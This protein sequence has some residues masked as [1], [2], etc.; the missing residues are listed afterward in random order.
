VIEPFHHLESSRNTPPGPT[1]TWSMFRWEAARSWKM[2]QPWDSSLRRVRPADCPVL[3][4]LD[5]G[6]RR[7]AGNHEHR[8]DHAGHQACA[9]AQAAPLGSSQVG[10]DDQRSKDGRQD[11]EAARFRRSQAW[12]N[13]SYFLLAPSP[14]F[15]D[16]RGCTMP[17]SMS[18]MRVQCGRNSNPAWSTPARCQVAVAQPTPRRGC[19]LSGQRPLPKRWKLPDVCRDPV[20]ACLRRGGRSKMPMSP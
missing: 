8:N 13:S 20:D 10:D 6:R 15:L 12:V 2:R 1:T 14:A 11:E 19:A 5:P 18:P 16:L 17:T 3:P 4:V 9:A 7:H